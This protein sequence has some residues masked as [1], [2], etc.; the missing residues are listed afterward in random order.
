MPHFHRRQRKLDRTEMKR[1]KE[2]FKMQRNKIREVQCTQ[3]Q[4]SPS[5]YLAHIAQGSRQESMTDD[6]RVALPAA[7]EIDARAL[8][9]YVGMLITKSSS[10]I[11]GK[12]LATT[13]KLYIGKR[14]LINQCHC[15]KHDQIHMNKRKK[16]TNKH[17]C[18]SL[19]IWPNSSTKRK[20]SI[21]RHYCERRLTQ[22]TVETWERRSK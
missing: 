1:K 12:Q 5:D 19:M 20:K 22:A 6:I 7:E 8:C 17:T 15:I 3:E 16:K 4:C 14:K 13:L 9:P 18:S 10:H 2:Y 11:G 21:S